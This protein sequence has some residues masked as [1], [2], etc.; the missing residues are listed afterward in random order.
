MRVL[1]I[2]AVNGIRSTGRTVKELADCLN[3]CGHE[4]YIAYSDGTSYE[5]GFLIGSSFEKKLHALLSRLTGLQGY[6]SKRGTRKLLAYMD[7]IQPD[8]VCLRNLHGNFI[9][10]R[11]L[12]GYLAKKDI[13]TVIALH[14]C[15]YF[16]GKCSHYAMDQ[17]SRW[18]E[19]CG[20]CPRLHKD[21]IS[22]FF[23][24]THR[25]L[26]DKKRWYSRVPRLAAVGV[27]D[28]ITDEARRSILSS[29][30][31][32]RRIHN[33]VDLETFRPVAAEGL[34]ES[35]CLDSMFVVLGVASG[36]SKAKG[37]DRFI[38]LADALPQGMAIVLV[39]GIGG[40]AALPKRIIHI[41][42]THSVDQMAG[43]YSMAD[44]L[45]N[46]SPE[47]SFGKVTAE[48][49]ACGSPAIVLDSTASPELVEPGCGHIIS[50]ETGTNE[51]V[52]LLCLVRENGK[53]SYS[54]ACVASAQRRFDRNSRMG[55]YIDLFSE[56]IAF[57]DQG[58]VRLPD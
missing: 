38:E 46:L 26:E 2:N 51:L 13:P 49:L 52:G 14:D 25:M 20:N 43:L 6:F 8:A 10:L 4:G 5:K 16:T 24:R 57:K 30:K 35:L 50:G 39:G 23:D 11:M 31:I 45:L 17:C 3:D 40:Q 36:W 1:Q 22:W 58:N 33:W 53:A 32:I 34:K 48:A 54:K 15:W 27:S 56:L 47:E 29:A 41:P 19:S 44:V 18:Q 21:N 28:W 12:F 42:E 55:D 37:L 7:R 9:N